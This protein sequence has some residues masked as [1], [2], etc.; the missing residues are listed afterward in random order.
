MTGEFL[1]P[2]VTRHIGPQR[3]R[4]E[5][6]LVYRQGSGRRIVVP[7]GFV[8]DGASVPRG[9]WWLYPSFGE[10]YEPATWLHDYAYQHA[11]RLDVS[12]RE[13]DALLYEAAIGL[14]FRRSGAR[15]LWLGVRVGGWWP[16]RQARRR[17][18][19]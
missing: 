1:T 6:D 5:G 9:F 15:A 19:A 4:L 16:W 8:A 3:K 10:A 14:G 12:R 18:T 17:E 11:E 7:T 13:A 2:L